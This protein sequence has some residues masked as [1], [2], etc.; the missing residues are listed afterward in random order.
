VTVV[1]GS[2]MLTL[3]PRHFWVTWRTL[4]YEVL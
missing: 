1:K 3:K 4:F 2:L